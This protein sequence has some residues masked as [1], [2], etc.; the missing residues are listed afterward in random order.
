M[1]A[2]T[3]PLG[4]RVEYVRMGTK[5]S[6]V[7]VPENKRSRDQ[8][9]NLADFKDMYEVIVKLDPKWQHGW[10]YDAISRGHAIA[11][12]EITKAGPRTFKQILMDEFNDEI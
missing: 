2:K 4:T 8:I 7:L 3:Y 11:W 10:W 6:G 5:G 1:A 9:G 12:H